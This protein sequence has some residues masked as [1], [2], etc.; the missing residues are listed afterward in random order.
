MQ[1]RVKT[2]TLQKGKIKTMKN[3]S[4]MHNTCRNDDSSAQRLSEDQ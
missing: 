2:L 4:K 1:L 3:E